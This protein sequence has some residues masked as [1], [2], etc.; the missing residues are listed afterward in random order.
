MSEKSGFSH[1]LLKWF[2]SEGR[3]FPWRHTDDPYK[4]LVAEK[5]L[6]QTSVR[7]VLVDLYLYL[8][9]KYPTVSHLAN[10]DT[11]ELTERIQPLGLH[12]RAKELVLMANDI[13]EKLNGVIPA[14]LKTLLSIY[15][16]GDY[17]ARAVLSFAYDQDIAVVDTNVARI[18]YRV[19]SIP[20][21][22]PENPARKRTL[23]QIANSLLPHKKSREFN[24]AMIDLG[25]LVCLPLRPL[26]PN[27]PLNKICDFNFQRRANERAETQM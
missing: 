27:C 10:A 16:V 11:Q 12:Y 21:K 25:A 1:P 15:G 14:D 3:D 5:L 17:S 20:G 13:Q 18:L 6:Q 4:I 23:H 22:F 19:Y 8:T 26:C 9:E 2:R 7:K 24:W